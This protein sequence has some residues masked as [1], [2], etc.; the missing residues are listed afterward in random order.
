[1]FTLT[2]NTKY[3]NCYTIQNPMLVSRNSGPNGGLELIMYVESD[4]YIRG[5]TDDTGLQVMVHPPQTLAFPE[6]EGLA[7]GGG[8]HSFISLKLVKDKMHRVTLAPHLGVL[9]ETRRVIGQYK[10]ACF[11]FGLMEKSGSPRGHYN[12]YSHSNY[13]MSAPDD[14]MSGRYDSPAPPNTKQWG[15]QYENFHIRDRKHAGQNSATD[16]RR[17]E[18]GADS[19]SGSPATRGMRKIFIRFAQSCSMQGPPYIYGSKLAY[20]KFLW[21]ILTLTAFGFMAFH[22]FFLFTTYLAFPVK[23]EINLGFSNLDFPSVTVC[24]VN[25]VRM[26]KLGL[27]SEG[28]RELVDAIKPET[29]KELIDNLPYWTETNPD[30]R[31][32]KRQAS[33]VPDF[34]DNFIDDLDLGINDL[35]FTNPIEDLGATDYEDWEDWEDSWEAEGED[36]SFYQLEQE[37]IDWYATQDRQ[38]RIDAGHQLDDMLVS[39]SFA[40]KKCHADN[41]T[42]TTSTRYGNCYSI[43]S[44]KFVSRKS[45]PNGG[46]ELIMYLETNEYIRGITA[47][48]GLQVMIHPRN[49]ITFP[50]DEGLA[51][52]G[53]SHTFLSL[54]LVQIERKGGVYSTCTSSELFERRY[55]IK[56]TRQ[57]CQKFC[58]QS[59]IHSRCSCRDETQEDLNIVMKVEDLRACR[60]QKDTKCMRRAYWDFAHGRVNCA[61]NNPCTDIKY[62]KTL[63]FRPWPHESFAGLLVKS[64]CHRESSSVCQTLT[65]QQTADKHQLSQNFV[66]LNIFYEDLNYENITEKPDYEDA[67]FISDVGGTLGLWIGLSVLSI[68]EVFQLVLELLRHFCCCRWRNGTSASSS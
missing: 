37:L 9:Q 59:T 5:L 38:S 34:S 14:Q 64:L 36:S 30:E 16:D 22:L 29:L 24:N 33:A 52:A 49:T 56:Y 2:T 1:N 50:A 11:L 41:F 57:T 28:F 25:P 35:N 12:D 44:Q 21:V 51:I 46:L 7:I 67:Q 55:K 32:R 45:G 27:L 17:S 66:K 3:G 20:A 53:G 18:N 39:C 42:L 43:S 40:G 63:S 68:F 47:D 65:N 23:N 8:T 48:N 26:S 6:N 31:R 54:K 60:V 15:Q 19:N 58:E 4:D 13:A 61:C 62:E 10:P